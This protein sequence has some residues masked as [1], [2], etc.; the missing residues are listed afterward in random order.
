[1]KIIENNPYRQLGVYANSPIKERIAN[2]NRLQAFLK[3]GRQVDF[4]LDLPHYLPSIHRTTETIA[5][6]DA[7]LALPKE[8]LKYA[9][10]WFIKATPLDDIAFNHLQAGNMNAAIDIWKKKD[11]VSSLQNRI[12]CALIEKNYETAIICAEQF[13]VQ[14]LPDFVA[15]MLGNS[16][17]GTKQSLAFDFIDIICEEVGANIILPCITNESWKEHVAAVQ[18]K[19][20]IANIE[21]AIEVA[22]SSRGKG[23]LARY[24][25]GIKLK[26]DTKASLQ[27]LSTFLPTT[28]LQYQMIADKLG[29]EILQCGI[30]YYNDS[31]D[32]DAAYK[33]MEL[34]KY[35]LSIVV[36]KMAKDRCEE[37]VRILED[38]IS[39]LPPREIL[40]SHEA[41]QFALMIFAIQPKII[42]SSIQLIKDC[43]PHI[44]SIKEELGKNHQYYLNISTT[45][46][47]NALGN[48][49]SEVNE[50][51]KKDFEILKSTLISAWRTQLYMDMFDLEA[52]YKA[53]RFK[54]CRAALHDIIKN[55]KGFENSQNSYRY[56]YGC[57]WCNNLDVSD[58]DLRTDD[59][60]F[61]SCRVL[62]SYKAYLQ[63][64]PSGKH[65]SEVSSKI[66]E[67]SY[68]SCK[69]L[70]DYQKFL[71]DYPNSVYQSK[72]LVAI[73]KLLR[74]EEE[75]KKRIARQ[76]KA[77]STCLTLNDVFSLYVKEKSEGIDIDKCSNKALELAKTEKDFQ[78]VF[79]TFGLR[80]SG[81]KKAKAK[82]EEFERIRKEKAKSRAKKL[83]WSLW[84]GIPILII[85]SLYLIW[86][87][88][89][90]ANACIIIAFISGFVAFGS[91]KS[92]DGCALFFISATIAAI[93][94]FSGYG[95]YKIADNVDNK[96]KSK[97][98]YEQ[99]INNPTEKTCSDYVRKFKY[100]N[101]KR[102]DKVRDIWLNLLIN[103]SQSFDYESYKGTDLSYG[104]LSG[105]MNPIQKIQEFIDQNSNTNYQDKA[106]LFMKSIC[107]SLYNIADQKSTI[108]GWK[109]YQRIVPTDY[110][111]D[112][113]EKLEEIENRTWNTEPQ[114]W[115]QATLEN[116]ISA[117]EK[118]KSLYPNG[119]HIGICEKKLIDLEVSHIYA[120]E[121]GTL[122]SMNRTGYG[123]GST[124]YIT[125]TNSTSYTL[126]IWYS[127]NDSKKL[128]IRAGGTKS[129]RLKN[130]QY[131]VAASVSAS[132]VRN[133]AGSENLLGG[134]YSVDYYISTYRY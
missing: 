124:S 10:F 47:N 66:I 113:D 42:K 128:V 85:I 53:G 33:A 91:M 78:N 28:D 64:F 71:K 83:K 131:R 98:L 48:V 34:Q 104:N 51:Q 130:G 111:R 93:F 80:S 26:N 52:A 18:I 86:D 4:P 106:Q 17:D 8:Q 101:A 109:Q 116:S 57:G 92:E 59:E 88:R 35:A 81:G 74:E 65:I 125:V 9:Q 133:Y 94:G 13:Y 19:P 49:I 38:T 11:C 37:N 41:I 68:K 90:I 31:N 6:A 54:E 32:I 114:A 84:I 24:Q 108:L 79:S 15:M 95:L 72:V 14:Y 44:V 121:H 58:V 107:D 122:P 134:S 12:V 105:T 20:I 50:A 100:V 1:M 75:R 3:V 22:K 77:I 89:G 40:D 23:S 126:T 103:E 127:G 129:V 119:S 76:E 36:G 29:L 46:V 55:C 63:R 120:G 62:A 87:I 61:V 97:K 2:H 39:Q 25:A 82:I 123:S 112:S 7:S 118:Y 73:D 43:A 117:Y 5:Q 56:Q 102:T 132:N 96:N 115:Q 69:T 45:I 27:Q 60:F 99:I 30:D 110:F 70:A 16:N 67:L 21:A